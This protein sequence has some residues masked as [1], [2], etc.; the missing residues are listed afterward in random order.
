MYITPIAFDKKGIATA[1]SAAQE[2]VKDQGYIHKATAN[3][4]RGA[5]QRALYSIFRSRL[6]KSKRVQ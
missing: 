1:Y 3:T 6:I 2:Y 5:T 4:R